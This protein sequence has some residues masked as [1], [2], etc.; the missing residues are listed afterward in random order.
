M[1]SPAPHPP[2]A[3]TLVE[4]L[5]VIGVIAILIALLLPA[6]GRARETANRAKCLATLRSMAQA[7]HLHASEHLGY[8]PAAG[9]QGP[10]EKGVFATPAGM[11]DSAR[12]KYIYFRD[13]SEVVRPAPLPIALGHYM[14]LGPHVREAETHS[15]VGRVLESEEVRR[16]FVCAS[17]DPDAVRPGYT[18][19]DMGTGRSPRAYMSYFFNASALARQIHTWGETPAG[20]LQR[21]KRPA[22]VFLFA[23]GK[24]WS[25]DDFRGLGISAAYSTRECLYEDWDRAGERGTPDDRY[26]HYRHRGRM[27]VVFV[28]GHGETVQMPD[29][30]RDP[31][32]M[33]DRGDFERIGV[34][35]G[36]FD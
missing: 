26:D 16:H 29:F 27:N 18:I 14:N 10:P 25:R 30:R 15:D 23:D 11:L 7:A 3:F 28:D 17:Q 5:V 8:M 32:E 31:D 9:H 19:S 2:R 33:R 13:S 22:E 35:K 20:K 1:K 12:R 21:I 4:L 34:S 6:L 24:P 36:I